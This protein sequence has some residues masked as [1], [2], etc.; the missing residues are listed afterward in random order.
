MDMATIAGFFGA[1]ALIGWAMHNGGSLL[2]YIDPSSLLIVFGGTAATVLARYRWR[3]FVSHLKAA[4]LVFKPAHRDPAPLAEVMAEWAKQ[5][6]D[7]GRL[8]L[9]GIAET[10]E[11]VFIRHGLQLLADGADEDKLVAQ[12]KI[13]S[14][15]Q[16]A[17]HSQMITMWQSWADVAP[18]MGMIG[19]LVGLVQMLGNMSDP[20]A[21]GPA[22]ALALL[23][24]L[25]GAILAFVIAGPIVQKLIQLAKEDEIYRG[26]VVSGLCMIAKGEGPVKVMTA[27]TALLPATPANAIPNSG[28]KTVILERKAP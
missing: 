9:E 14:D 15:H 5:V 16:I 22:M 3:D 7:N 23:T 6:R 10:T 18:A 13:A 17:H 25:Y 28:D 1:L 21:I 19:T 2:A 4:M 26:T 11:D 27:M 20:R 8:S 24:T 12:L